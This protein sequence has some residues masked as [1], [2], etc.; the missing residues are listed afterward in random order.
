[1]RLSGVRESNDFPGAAIS[2]H[3]S[4]GVSVSGAMIGG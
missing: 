3:L 2:D 1:M 4:L